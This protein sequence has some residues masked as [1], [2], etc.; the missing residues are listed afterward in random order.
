MFAGNTPQEKNNTL[1][2]ITPVDIE[3]LNCTLI[4]ASTKS[5]SD[6]FNNLKGEVNNKT[7][8]FAAFKSLV[9]DELHE[10]KEKV[11]NLG[12]QNQMGAVLLKI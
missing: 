11:Y 12:I 6:R 1:P 7:A 4:E 9:L 8:N 3:T 5:D 2:D 10:F